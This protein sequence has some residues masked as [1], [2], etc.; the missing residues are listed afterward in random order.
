MRIGRFALALVTLLAFVLASAPAS[1][2]QAD[3]CG[4]P[5]SF[6][7]I[8]ACSSI[9]DK[10]QHAF[11]VTTHEDA[12]VLY[13]KLHHTSG[14]GI[15]GTVTAPD[16][17]G[18]CGFG[19]SYVES[20][21]LGTA[22]TYTI[23]VSLSSGVGTAGYSLTAESTRTPSSC[24][25]LDRS[26]FSFASPGVTGTL[27]TGASAICYR[28][29]QPVGSVLRL[30][31]PGGA[32]D[33][34]GSI[35]DAQ[36]QPL[37]PI[38]TTTVCTLTQPGPYRLFLFEFYG[39]Q[40]GYTLKMPRISRSVGCP[41]LPI[42]PFGD[43][44]AAAGTATVS[45]GVACH[46][47]SAPSA[48]K[49]AV[50]VDPR[51]D[52]AWT[53]YN[54][55]G[56]P[57]C[58]DYPN[59][60]DCDLPAAGDHTLLVTQRYS[61]DDPITYQVAI[62]AL[63]G[64]AGCAAATGTSWDLPALL[65]HQ[66]SRVQ[67]NCQPFTGEAGDR[68]IAYT[69]P[70]V[71]SDL[72]A[73]IA[74]STGAQVCPHWTGE[75]GCVLPA[76]GTYRVISY[77]RSWGE[78]PADATYK[79]QVRRLSSPDGCPTRTAGPYG[80]TPVPSGIRC[81][82]LDV[83]GPGLYT[84]KA[85]DARNYPIYAQVYDSAGLRVCGSPQ[86]EFAMPGRYTMVLEGPQT[87]KVIDNDV[88]YATVFL[89]TVPSG[90]PQISDDVTQIAT[91][92]GQF[93]GAGQIQCLELTSPAGA[94]VIELLPGDASG[95]GQPEVTVVDST[96]AWVCDSSYGLRQASCALSG[97]APFFAVFSPTGGYATGL[98]AM[99]F[100][101]VDGA[102]GCPVLPRTTDGTTV[103]TSADR[104][105]TCFSIPADEHGTREVFT[106]RRTAGTG[107]ATIA[108]F[109]GTGIRYCRTSP[110]IDRTVTCSLPAGPATVILEADGVDATY[111]L[112]HRAP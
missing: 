63:D 29:H 70:T 102:P 80:A 68:I 93:N 2:H 36:H 96:G 38:E 41:T 61:A 75:D 110:S 46:K 13:A 57:V 91:H 25:K 43:P 109:D 67:T 78:Q 94:K 92:R 86:C 76:S 4:G 87:T 60:R 90:C 85:V 47:V 10:Q 73:W 50:R 107:D 55:A 34:R 14:D 20:C 11:T 74:D 35:L 33:V 12:D 52:L 17:E 42:A 39:N 24:T 16:G 108:V 83:T 62:P 23:T 112:T 49:V 8:V 27:P 51:Q 79:L 26:F 77:V 95:A 104:Y 98:Y 71:Y 7:E 66:T 84:L 100:P 72:D 65:V 58:A 28:F 89:P 69:T 40:S 37:C 32:G 82:I 48:G 6:G 3:D 1:A 31:D 19:P 30:A 21:Q 54:D 111:Q 64:A 97:T 15:V 103:D 105:A 45:T 88:Q 44:G 101:R 106:Y 22:G 18:V 5:L 99:A 81:R 53:L 59:F 56:Q 9:T